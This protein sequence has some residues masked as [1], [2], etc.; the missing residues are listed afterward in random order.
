MPSKI[1][2]TEETWNPVVGCTNVSE[3]CRHCYARKMSARLRE[4]ERPEYA[5]LTTGNGTGAKWT[6]KVRL[7]SERLSKPLKWRK[8]RRV[9]VNS[10]SDLFHE[11]LSNEE[12]AA[13]FGVMAACPQH[14]FQVLTKRAERMEEWFGWVCSHYILSNLYP[15]RLLDAATIHGF[16]QPPMSVGWPLRNVWL[17]V[18][19]EDQATA[20]ERIPHLL[21]CP[22]N[23]RWV[24]AEPLLGPVDLLPAMLVPPDVEYHNEAG[25]RI[26]DGLQWVVVGGESGPSARPCEYGWL[27]SVVQQC[28]RV[29]VPCFVKQAGANYLDTINGIAGQQAKV[30]P[31]AGQV[32]RL[33]HP[34]GGNPDEWPSDLRIREWPDA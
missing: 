4:M 32:R 9:F 27:R 12:I 2:W 22:T 31:E 8:P 19:V 34:K 15:S 20:D 5:D 21:R 6:G 13:V 10:M 25:H 14:T 1:Q 17:G 11:S 33:R 29:G 7:L 24:S 16:G 26:Y 30:P 23:I 28:R 3:G 18:S